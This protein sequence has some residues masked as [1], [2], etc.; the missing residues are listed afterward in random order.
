MIVVVETI[1]DI[2]YLILDYLCYQCGPHTNNMKQICA[3]CLGKG[4]K[5]TQ[6]GEQIL[7]FVGREFNLERCGT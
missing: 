6:L 2:D 5:L 1:E 3:C 4:Y 7:S